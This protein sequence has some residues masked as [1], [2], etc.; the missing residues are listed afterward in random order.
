MA[1]AV[2]T[3]FAALSRTILIRT[4]RQTEPMTM[5]AIPTT[6]SPATTQQTAWLGSTMTAPVTHRHLIAAVRMMAVAASTMVEGLTA[7][8]VVAT[9]CNPRKREND[10][11]PDRLR[12]PILH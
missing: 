3:T 7:T 11:P 5:A 12:R 4:N 10:G 8:V 9:F 6:R 2:G 1:N